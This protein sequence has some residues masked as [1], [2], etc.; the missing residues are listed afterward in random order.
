[1]TVINA[2][3]EYFNEAERAKRSRMHRNKV[4]KGAYLGLQN[5]D[6]KNPGQSKEFL[7]KTPVA[8]EQLAGFVKRALTQFGQ[9]YEVELGRGNL[10]QGLNKFQI[11]ELMNCFLD[12]LIVEDNKKSNFSTLLT[13]AIKVGALESLIV[14]KVHGQQGKDRRKVVDTLEGAMAPEGS[15]GASFVDL[16]N[17]KLRIDLVRPED[18]YPDPTGRGLYEIHRTEQD[19]HTVIEKADKGI[20]DKRAVNELLGMDQELPDFEKRRAIDRNQEEEPKP[21]FRKTVVVDEFW[22]DIL[23]TEGKVVHKNVFCAIANDKHLIRPPK[24]NPF[25]HQESPFIAVPLIRVPFSVW[26]KALMDHAVQLNLAANELFN[27]I[28]DGGIS[29]VWGIKQIRMQDLEDPRQVS[30]G[31]PQGVTLAVKDTLPHGSKVVETVTEGD[32]PQDAMA[33]LEM[34]SREFTAAALSNELKMGSLPAKQVLATE[35]VELSQSQAVTLDAITSDIERELIK[36]VLEKSWKTILQNM[37]DVA[38]DMVIS[39][40]GV[41]GAFA[42]SQ[43]TPSQRYQMMANDCAFKVNGLSATLTRVR[44][45]QKTMA[46]LQSVMGNPVLLQ[47]FFSRYS[48]N[49]ILAHLMKTLN[50]NPEQMER[51]EIELATLDGEI[52]GLGAFQQII[53]PP[54]RGAETGGA[55]LGAQDAGDA[56]LPAEINQAANPLTGLVGQ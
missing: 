1:L 49:R 11:Y 31:I 54:N 13:D 30:D 24:P 21:S 35:V 19:I 2:V 38:S 4:N 25:W 47:A 15:E 14:L 12:N 43:M 36:R 53:N 44:D 46:L 6:H 17:W 56:S 20:Y 10:G 48:P 50:V 37:D 29:A 18:Y 7:P 3:K 45:F 39:A 32:V 16:D 40:L 33:T 41:D 23:D 22:G 28:I 55:G 8:V 5:W 26:H 51:D 9:W 52:Q 27:L 34:L 42:L